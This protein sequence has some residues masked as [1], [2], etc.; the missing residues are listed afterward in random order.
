MK[1]VGH[2]TPGIGNQISI[3]AQMGQPFQKILPIRIHAE[4]LCPLDTSPHDVMQSSRSIQ[5]RLPRHVDRVDPFISFVK[6]F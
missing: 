2:E 6:L 5:S 1:M 4:Y 3:H